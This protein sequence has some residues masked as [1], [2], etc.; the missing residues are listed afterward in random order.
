MARGGSRDEFLRALASSV[1]LS[2]D[3]AHAIHPNY[4]ERH[5]PQHPVSV[6][7]GPVIKVNTNQRYATDAQG[8]A[9]VAELARSAGV[10]HQEFVSRNDQP[11]GSTIGPTTAARLGITTVD[12]GVAQL[13]MHSARELCG[14]E[15][16]RHLSVLL[17]TFLR[18]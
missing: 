15:D 13:S 9:M 4:P 17:S 10:P 6:N 11:C 16:P 3:M 7:A 14:A 5:D 12:I 8:R 1:A 18:S 2:V